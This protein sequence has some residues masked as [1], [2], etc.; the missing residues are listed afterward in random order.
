M[1]AR[2][3]KIKAEVE[4]ALRRPR[5]LLSLECIDLRATLTHMVEA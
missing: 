1:S 3:G 5:D 2:P 4:V